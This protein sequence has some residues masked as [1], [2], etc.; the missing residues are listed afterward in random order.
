M[1]SVI[2][3]MGFT[4][5]FLIV[6]DFIRYAK[7]NGVPVGPGR[8]SAA[9]S[10]VAYAMRIT[11]LDPIEH[12]LIFERFLNPARISMPDI[13]VDF[14]INGRDRVY[15]YVV[16]QYGGGDY[17]AQI[18]TYG[19]LK[20]R[21]VIRDVGRALDIPL[22]GRWMPL[23]KWCPMSSISVWRMPSPRSPNLMSWRR[24]ETGNRRAAPNL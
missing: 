1:K 17:V 10:M 3:E 20:T 24:R 18:I 4:G 23:P 7:E 8:G 6:A 12:G 15:K 19:K 5:Y 14:C 2:K 21:A 22:C 13:D 9:G 16:D 11:D